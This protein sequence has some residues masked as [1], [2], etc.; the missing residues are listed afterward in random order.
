MRRRAAVYSSSS[1]DGAEDLDD[2]VRNMLSGNDELQRRRCLSRSPLKLGGGTATGLLERCSA[3]S[4]CQC[5]LLLV[6]GGEE[7]GGGTRGWGGPGRQ[8]R[9]PMKARGSPPPFNIVAT[10][11]VYEDGQA[12]HIVEG[13]CN[14]Q[15]AAEIKDDDLSIKP[16]DFGHILVH[17]SGSDELRRRRCLSRSPLKLGGGTATG[18]FERCCAESELPHKCYGPQSD[19]WSSGVVLYVLLSGVPPF[20]AEPQGI[21][22][23]VLKGLIDFQSVL[24][25]SDSAKDLIGKMLSHYPSE[26]EDG[27]DE[28]I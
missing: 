7:V 25:I 9:S 27:L 5:P 18:L 24:K 11:D 6:D 3:G 12:V 4:A 23:A 19:V 13:H 21:Y 10:K 28:G 17:L 8:R 26:C 16:I 15:K 2:G 14:E 22:D 1:L 20:W